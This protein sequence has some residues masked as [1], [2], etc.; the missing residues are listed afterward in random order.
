MTQEAVCSQPCQ[1]HNCHYQFGKWAAR[2]GCTLHLVCRRAFDWLFIS[3]RNANCTRAIFTFHSVYFHSSPITRPSSPFLGGGGLGNKT[4]PSPSDPCS[5][6]LPLPLPLPS[7]S[8][9]LLHAPLS[10]EDLPS[11][12]QRE[13]SLSWSP[14]PPLHH[15]CHPE[16][17]HRLQCS[18]AP[19]HALRLHSHS[20]PPVRILHRQTDLLGGGREGIVEQSMVMY[21]S[22]W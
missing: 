22:V 16:N 20:H 18:L 3:I 8:P 7:L 13:E 11:P 9:P 1:L 6:S 14:L 17:T 4:N 10:C 2:G 19:P 12:V 5:L 21:G 15:F